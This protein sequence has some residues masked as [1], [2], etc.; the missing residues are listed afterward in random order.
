MDAFD[1]GI[2]TINRVSKARDTLEELL[3][4]DYSRLKNQS[5]SVSAMNV[6]NKSHCDTFLHTASCEIRSFVRRII[7]QPGLQTGLQALSAAFGEEWLNGIRQL[8]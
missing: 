6:R 2:V 5:L 4:V 3:Q 8:S 1:E 7:L